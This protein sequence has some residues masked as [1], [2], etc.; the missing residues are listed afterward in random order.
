MA[1]VAVQEQVNPLITGE[2]ELSSTE[3]YHSIYSLCIP[4]AVGDFR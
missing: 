3:H 1:L 4:V 2:I